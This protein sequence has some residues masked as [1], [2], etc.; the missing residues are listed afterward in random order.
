L[1]TIELH[2][3]GYGTKLLMPFYGTSCV[4]LEVWRKTKRTNQDS[5][6]PG[7]ESNLGLLKIV[8]RLRESGI[9]VLRKACRPRTVVPKV[10]GQEILKGG[11]GAR[12]AKLFYSLKINKKHKYNYKN[13]SIT[14]WSLK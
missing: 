4:F 2:W 3:K 12:G 13:L 14:G 11:G 1:R 7:R 9:K 6:S 10:W 8:F 5:Q